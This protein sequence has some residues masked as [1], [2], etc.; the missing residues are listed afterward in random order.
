MLAT[1]NDTLPSCPGHAEPQTYYL[2]PSKPHALK[3]NE[4]ISLDAQCHKFC[5][6]ISRSKALQSSANKYEIVAHI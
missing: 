6:F 4:L 1:K 2:M 3:S 5:G